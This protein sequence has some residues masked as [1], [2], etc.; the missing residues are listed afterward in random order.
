MKM[1]IVTVSALLIGVGEFSLS[2]AADKTSSQQIVA[3][4]YMKSAGSRIFGIEYV[5]KV[6]GVPEG[7]NKSAHECPLLAIST[8]AATG[9]NE[10]CHSLRRHGRSA[11]VRWGNRLARFWIAE[12]SGCCASG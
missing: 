9:Q 11:S 8:K 2:V 7:A 6:S 1:E 10:P 12:E 5:G 4:E 3:R